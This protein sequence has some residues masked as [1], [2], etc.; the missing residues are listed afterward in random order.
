[1]VGN[2]TKLVNGETVV[3]T[4]LK[5]F[6]TDV[7]ANT[8]YG[9][10]NLTDESINFVAVGKVNT[11]NN[12]YLMVRAEAGK[13]ST[14]AVDKIRDQAS[15]T[16]T[17]VSVS[18]GVLWGKTAKGWV[19]LNDVELTCI[20]DM[21]N[22]GGLV[23]EVKNFGGLQ[24]A[25]GSFLF[26]ASP[27]SQHLAINVYDKI[28]GNS[29]GIFEGT[30]TCIYVIRV[31]ASGNE[32]WG[33]VDTLEGEVYIKLSDVTYGDF[34]SYVS[35]DCD[36]TSS[37]GGSAV[38][39]SFKKDNGI[40]INNLT[41][42]GG[43]MY[44][45]VKSF[46]GNGSWV[47]AENLSQWYQAPAVPKKQEILTDSGTG[48]IFK[49]TM[50]FDDALRE[51]PG[52]TQKGTALAGEPVLVVDLKA[53]D[54]QIWAKVLTKIIDPAD[55]SVTASSRWVHLSSINGYTASASA[56]YAFYS[57]ASM[58]E[59]SESVQEIKKGAT[60]QVLSIERG[61][62]NTIWG[63]VEYKDADGNTTY[64]Y[65]L[66]DHVTFLTYSY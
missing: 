9:W 61:A 2:G 54:T 38:V 31:Q 8:K 6:G 63:K 64:A 13:T 51:T 62:Y 41:A 45:Q 17:G 40:K 55:N 34:D 29:I 18:N 16:L 4:A 3:I 56:N 66:A 5:G 58:L 10:F 1:M 11:R 52:G 48:V 43:K 7:W 57:R 28:N 26:G 44:A 14:E 59:T 39:G 65:I 27:K 47:A 53:D 49:S 21:T 22:G 42:V 25:P 30:V 32:V 20:K 19:D 50:K 15:I 37:A 23:A 33:V 12:N 60:V 36:A 24:K 46:T 35:V